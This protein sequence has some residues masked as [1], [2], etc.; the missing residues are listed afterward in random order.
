MSDRFT[1]LFRSESKLYTTSSPIIIDTQVILKDQINKNILA[2]V[3]YVS[4]APQ[5][6]TS[7]K[8]DV[9]GFEPSGE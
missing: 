9:L 6:I 5:P 7:L 1:E 4:V 3:K 8:V 2:L